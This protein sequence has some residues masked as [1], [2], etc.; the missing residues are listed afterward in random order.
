MNILVNRDAP[1]LELLIDGFTTSSKR[2]LKIWITNGRIL[3]N[4][5]VV[6]KPHFMVKKGQE[7][8]LKDKNKEKPLPAKIKLLYEDPHFL[9]IEKPSGLLSVPKDTPN[10]V[11]VLK[12]LRVHYNTKNIFAVHRI[13]KGAS[14]LLLFAKS[15]DV[16]NT[17]KEIFKKHDITRKYLAIVEGDFL[18][19]EGTWK[20]YLYEDKNLNVHITSQDKGV[21]AITNFKKILYHNNYS[22]ILLTLETGKKHQIRVQL[23]EKGFPIIGD[24]KYG[25]AHSLINRLCLHAFLLEFIHPFTKEKISFSSEIPKE[26]TVF[27]ADKVKKLLA[28]EIS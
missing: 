17:F 5:Q 25:K 4:N 2:T 11:N 1:L 28:K 14:G 16:L 10:S 13:D 15:F 12:I 20:T 3:V 6:K 26:F 23:K 8:L 7:I 22:F 24:K 27:G 19:E 18:E 9:I 21:L